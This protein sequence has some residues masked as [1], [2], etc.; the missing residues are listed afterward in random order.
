MKKSI[1][2]LFLALLPIGL[3]GQT[4]TS[5]LTYTNAGSWDLE[6]FYIGLI[7]GNTG[8]VSGISDISPLTD[9][10]GKVGWF[11]RCD[12]P[13]TY[14]YSGKGTNRITLHIGDRLYYNG[15]K[16]HKKPTTRPQ[17]DTVAVWIDC[18]DTTARI[19]YN[20]T[21]RGYEIK[22]ITGHWV[23]FAYLNSFKRPL[24][25]YLV[26]ETREGKK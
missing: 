22:K 6:S 14:D 20:V 12:N 7:D 11:G 10:G 26:W 4:D 9:K 16:W 3:M 8:M 2:I 18:A 23:P 5:K 24:T 17:V 13:G 1:F 15:E 21:M 25:G 19:N